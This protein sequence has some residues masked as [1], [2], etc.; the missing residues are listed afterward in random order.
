MIA[1]LTLSY[2]ETIMSAPITTEL[3][4]QEMSK[5][6]FAVLGFVT[7]KQEARTAG[8]VYIVEQRQVYISSDRTAWKTKHIQQNPHVSL[9]VTI[10]KSIPFMPFIKIPPAT[11]SFSGTA[12]VLPVTE[13]EEAIVQKVF[14]TT[15]VEPSLL[16]DTV[17]IRVTPH[18]EFMTYGVGVSLRT[19]QDTVAAHGRTA[20]G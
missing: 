2:K 14:R 13:V 1:Q 3:V 9:T 4:W 5:Q 19:M 15:K 12:V 20:V 16:A 11:I 17:I 18:G 8:I 6:M 7:P 10:P